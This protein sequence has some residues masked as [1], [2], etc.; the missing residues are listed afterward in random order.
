MASVDV[1]Q[2]EGEGVTKPA[3]RTTGSARNSVVIK[4]KISKAG[5]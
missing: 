5:I 1:L 4:K 3:T 2:G